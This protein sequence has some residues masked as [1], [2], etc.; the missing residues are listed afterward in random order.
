ML[1]GYRVHV[2]A[3]GPRR[4]RATTEKGAYFLD[5]QPLSALRCMVPG[6]FPRVNEIFHKI[7]SHNLLA[8]PSRAMLDDERMR[9][10]IDRYLHGANGVGAEERAAVFRLAWDFVGSELG[11]RNELYERYYF[12]SA[13]RHF[14]MAHLSGDRTRAN[15]AGRADAEAARIAE[16]GISRSAVDPKR[17]EYV[18][19]EAWLPYDYL[20]AV[21]KTQLKLPTRNRIGRKIPILFSTGAIRSYLPSLAWSVCLLASPFSIHLRR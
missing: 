14:Q 9:P 21:L 3:P 16:N 19:L 12:G 5:E 11:N 8:T 4:M 6:W 20:P 2:T 18:P 10:L 1:F 7:G 15:R 13:P 17:G